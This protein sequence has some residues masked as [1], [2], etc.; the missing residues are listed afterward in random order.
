MRKIF[1]LIALAMCAVTAGA[2]S[3]N[4]SEWE[5]KEYNENFTKDGLTIAASADAVV[6]IDGNKK[7]VDDVAYTQRLKFGGTGNAEAR[8]ISFEVAGPCTIEAVLCSASGSEERTLNICAGAY[9][10]ENVMTTMAAPAGAPVKTSYAYTG[11][12]TTIYM[13]S[14]KS[15][16]NLYAVYVSSDPTAVSAVRKDVVTANQATYNLAGQKVGEDV[17]GTVVVKNGKKYIRK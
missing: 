17:K 13:A 5:A 7:T 2:Q 12:A 10:A 9:D 6:T 1:T 15:G 3:W 14:A 4:F 11:E 8:N 16:V